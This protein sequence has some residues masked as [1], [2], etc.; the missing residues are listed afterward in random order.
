MNAPKEQGT[1]KTEAASVKTKPTAIAVSVIAAARRCFRHRFTRSASDGLTLAAASARALSR[2]FS[3][4]MVSLVFPPCN[5][6]PCF[7][8][9]FAKL[10]VVSTSNCHTLRC[11]LRA[12]PKTS[13]GLGDPDLRGPVCG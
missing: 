7:L 4:A 6:S 1:A 9:T 2:L 3:F 11:R 13:V 5:A 12:H 10:R 8:I